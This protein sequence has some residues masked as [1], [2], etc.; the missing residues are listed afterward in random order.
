[1]DIECCCLHFLFAGYFSYVT[2][3]DLLFI[4][5]HSLWTFVQS[6]VDCMIFSEFFALISMESLRVLYFQTNCLLT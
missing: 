6:I 3:R 5:R 1:M 2:V 4:F